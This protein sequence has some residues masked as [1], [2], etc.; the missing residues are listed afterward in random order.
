M[1]AADTKIWRKQKKITL[2]FV[3]VAFL[4]RLKPRAANFKRGVGQNSQPYTFVLIRRT[5]VWDVEIRSN[6]K[7]LRSVFYSI[8]QITSI[9]NADE[10]SVW[11]P[12]RFSSVEVCWLNITIKQNILCSS[13]ANRLVG[14]FWTNLCQCQAAFKMWFVYKFEC[15]CEYD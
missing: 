14:S 13:Y 9:F 10:L 5:K 4:S 15:K 3:R 12:V 6:T 8:K 2:V 7:Q 11:A 1:R